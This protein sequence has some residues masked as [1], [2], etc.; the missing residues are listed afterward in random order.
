MK[1]YLI[2]NVLKNK[3]IYLENSYCFICTKGKL[4]IIFKRQNVL[5]MY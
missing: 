1:K 4:Q 3:N 5:K 2:C